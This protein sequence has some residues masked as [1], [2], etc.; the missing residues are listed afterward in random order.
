MYKKNYELQFS[1]NKGLF[2]KLMF[3]VSRVNLI[4]FYYCFYCN[5]I[6]GGTYDSHLKLDILLLKKN[7]SYNYGSGLPLPHMNCTLFFHAKI[8]KLK[9]IH[10]FIVCNYMFKN[11]EKFRKTGGQH[12]YTTRNQNLACPKLQRLTIT[13]NIR[14][15][16][17]VHTSVMVYQ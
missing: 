16:F 14:F 15:S 8:L 9:D 10:E 12:H 5:K 13:L 17:P 3:N 7:Y 2:Y 6:W 11:V 4:E 1:K